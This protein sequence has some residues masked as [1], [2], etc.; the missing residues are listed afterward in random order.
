MNFYLVL[1]IDESQDII[2]RDRVTAMLK[3]ILVDVLV[4]DIDGLLAIEILGDNKQ[5]LT[6]LSGFLFFLATTQE[7][8]QLAPST[9]VGFVL[10][11][12]FVNV[13]FAQQDGLL[14][15]CLEEVFAI[16]HLVELSKLVSSIQRVFNAVLLK[17]L[18]EQVFARLLHFTTIAT[19]D[20]LNLSLG[21]RCADKANP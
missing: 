17:E 18:M 10:A 15:Q 20:G 12:Q 14:G 11:L 1:A 8:N 13:F 2:A 19:Q 16:A 6:L 21:L 9:L 5:F 4:A 3:L 7:G